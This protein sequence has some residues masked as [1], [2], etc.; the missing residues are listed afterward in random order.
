MYLL[1]KKAATENR[2]GFLAFNAVNGH[3]I[4][5][6]VFPMLSSKLRSSDVLKIR[7]IFTPVIFNYYNYFYLKTSISVNTIYD[8]LF[9]KFN[10][11]SAQ[12][13]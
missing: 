1:I 5:R 3:E 8:K 13:I 9:K 10:A 6:M 2:D 7:D 12:Y 4:P 11:W